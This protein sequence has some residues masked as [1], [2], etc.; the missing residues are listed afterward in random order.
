LQRDL[1]VSINFFVLGVF[2]QHVNFV[3]REDDLGRVDIKGWM[4][5]HEK[6]Q[7][8]LGALVLLVQENFNFCVACRKSYK[9]VYRTLITKK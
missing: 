6:K 9:S 1:K 8:S 5:D 7:F 4:E 2:M 3:F